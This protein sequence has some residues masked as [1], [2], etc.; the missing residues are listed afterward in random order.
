MKYGFETMDNVQN[1]S[2]VCYNTHSSQS[3]K[4]EV[5]ARYFIDST[6]QFH[7]TV[8]HYKGSMKPGSIGTEW[9][10]SACGRC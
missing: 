1:I 2:H 6:F 10:T 4:V 8:H 3:I 7:I 5:F 9:A